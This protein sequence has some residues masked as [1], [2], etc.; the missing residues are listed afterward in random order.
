M[1][2]REAFTRLRR[3]PKVYTVAVSDG[4]SLRPDMT[5]ETRSAKRA[6]NR[7]RAYE[8]QGFRVRATVAFE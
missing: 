5:L 3:T 4:V 2:S 1:S 8:R 6:V 7:Q